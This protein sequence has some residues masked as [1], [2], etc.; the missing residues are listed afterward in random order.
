MKAVWQGIHLLSTRHLCYLYPAA[1]SL[2]NIC[3]T[4]SVGCLVNLQSEI[5][6]LQC[7][8]ILNQFKDFPSLWNYL[9]KYCN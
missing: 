6:V 7:K 5:F 2:E 3:F 8:K 4:A 9:S 1:W